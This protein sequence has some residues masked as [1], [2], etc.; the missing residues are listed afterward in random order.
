MDD[1][2]WLKGE[3]IN[4]SFISIFNQLKVDIIS[5]RQDKQ[6]KHS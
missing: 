2:P 4:G 6:C 5:G 1:A 3:I